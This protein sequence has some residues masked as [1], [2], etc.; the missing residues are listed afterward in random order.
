[1]KTNPLTNYGEFLEFQWFMLNLVEWYE[2]N[3]GNY[4]H[5]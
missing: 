2:I 1:M 4:M 3:V 5:L